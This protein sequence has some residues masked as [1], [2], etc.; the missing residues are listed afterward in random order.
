MKANKN[1][2]IVRENVDDFF[3]DTEKLQQKFVTDSF[4]FSVHGYCSVWWFVGYKE[5]ISTSFAHDKR[6][7]LII[8]VL[9]LHLTDKLE[10]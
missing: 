8:D 7:F 4:V 10:L 5:S 2:R 3:S 6:I 9:V 1:I